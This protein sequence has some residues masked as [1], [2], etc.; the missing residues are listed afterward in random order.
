MDPVAAML[1]Q[2]MSRAERPQQCAQG[3][4]VCM[5]GGRGRSWGGGAGVCVWREGEG[6]ECVWKEGEGVGL[7]CVWREGVGLECVCV[8]VCEAAINHLCILFSS[9]PLLPLSSLSF[10]SLPLVPPSSSPPSLSF[11]RGMLFSVVLQPELPLAMPTLHLLLCALPLSSPLLLLLPR[12]T[13][14]SFEITSVCKL[15]FVPTRLEATI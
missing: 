2:C 8:C 4:L 6:L 9:F 15:S 10:L 5:C 11:S 3:K 12:L 7:E 14:A 13:L 1:K